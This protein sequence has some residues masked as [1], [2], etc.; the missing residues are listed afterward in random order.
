MIASIRAAASLLLLGASSFAADQLRRSPTGR[1]SRPSSSRRKRQGRRSGICRKGIRK[2]GFSARSGR[3]RKSSFGTRNIWRRSSTARARCFC[4]LAP[5]R[6]FSMLAWFLLTNSELLSMPDGQKLE[7]SLPPPLRARFVAARESI[8][9]KAS[10][11]EDDAP[12]VAAL[13]LENEFNDAKNFSWDE[14]RS[15]GREDR[16]RQACQSC[17]RSRIT[18]PCRWRK[19]CSS[20]ARSEPRLSGER[21]QRRR[22][23]RTARRARRPRP[24]RPAISRA[25]RRIIRPRQ[26]ES[27]ARQTDSFSKLDQRGVADSLAAIDEALSKPGKTVMLVDIGS[28]LRNTGVAEKLRAQGVVI[29]GPAD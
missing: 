15:H 5:V 25:S 12:V 29:E 10:H 13:K 23:A 11:Y 18:T 19:S 3:C 27:C 20:S 26:L 24:G 17:A 16:P 6:G 14:P 7:D 1:I 21:R 28:L 2:S 8:N 22:N 4:R 9:R